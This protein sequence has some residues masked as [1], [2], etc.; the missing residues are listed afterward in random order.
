M[1]GT[2]FK[3]DIPGLEKQLNRLKKNIQLGVRDGFENS[4][5][6]LIDR[7]TFYVTSVVYG[8]YF[9]FSDN[10]DKYQRTY[11]LEESIRAKVVGTSIYIYSEGVEYAERVL[12]GNDEI[13]YDFPFLGADSTG[14]FRPARDW[15]TPTKDEI[16]EHFNQSTGLKQIIIDAIQRRI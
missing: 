15:I 16:V 1:A 12:K 4:E 9:N 3:F 11:K 6:F 5:Q 7:M 8:A 2:G 14:D 10:P 13:P